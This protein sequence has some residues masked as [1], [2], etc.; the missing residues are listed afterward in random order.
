MVGVSVSITFSSHQWPLPLETSPTGQSLHLTSDCSEAQSRG[1]DNNRN[2]WRGGSWWGETLTPI[3]GSW[4]CV[5]ELNLVFQRVMGQSIIQ[6]GCKHICTKHAV[7][8]YKC[9]AIHIDIDIDIAKGEKDCSH[10][11]FVQSFTV[12][13][14]ACLVNICRYS[15]L[16]NILWKP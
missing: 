8:E 11:S 4:Y 7:L 6:Q 2:W 12:R 3:H 15:T 1:L 5:D 9:T 13:I 16:Q 14:S 10:L